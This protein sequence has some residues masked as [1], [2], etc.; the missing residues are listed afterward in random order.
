MASDNNTLIIL[1]S[2]ITGVVTSRSELRAVTWR[3]L[4]SHPPATGPLDVTRSP[5][6]I[7]FRWWQPVIEEHYHPIY[8]P[9]LQ[10]DSAGH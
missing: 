9:F 2:A 10:I 7:W 4:R 5:A 6:R 3:H 1:H 8:G